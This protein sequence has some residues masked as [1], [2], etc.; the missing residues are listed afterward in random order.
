MKL[1]LYDF[2]QRLMDC[3]LQI[4]NS[5]NE[6]SERYK[7]LRTFKKELGLE[8]YLETI[9]IKKFGDVVIQFRFGINRLKINN[10]YPAASNTG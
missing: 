2:K 8:K 4:W 10:R 9:D 1:L 7:W 6:N 5:T 3:Y